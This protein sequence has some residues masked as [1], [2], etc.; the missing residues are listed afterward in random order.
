MDGESTAKVRDRGRNERKAG[1]VG[2]V[3]ELRWLDVGT[4]VGNVM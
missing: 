2:G 1:S 3:R 4:W